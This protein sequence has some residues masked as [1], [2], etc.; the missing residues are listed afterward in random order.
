MGADVDEDLITCKNGCS[1][2]GVSNF[3]MSRNSAA[4]Y[5]FGDVDL[6][7]HPLKSLR[8][9]ANADINGLSCML[10]PLLLRRPHVPT[11]ELSSSPVVKLPRGTWRVPCVVAG[12]CPFVSTEA[13]L[14]PAEAE[15]TPPKMAE[16][17]ECAHR[18]CFRIADVTVI[19]SVVTRATG[20][21]AIGIVGA[22]LRG[23]RVDEV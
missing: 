9:R 21:I 17:D 6:L 5:I 4:C 3:L 14:R 18:A 1:S 10:L 23:E 11:K 2:E 16:T 15:G 22:P 19:H 13:A 7:L 8:R 20:S 12:R